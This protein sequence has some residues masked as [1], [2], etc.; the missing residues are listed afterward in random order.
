MKTTQKGFGAN[1]SDKI[2]LEQTTSFLTTERSLVSASSFKRCACISAHK[3]LRG[4]KASMV[5]L[6]R[7][8]LAVVWIA[9]LVFVAWPLALFLFPFYV[10]LQPFAAI[11]GGLGRVVKDIVDFMARYV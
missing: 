9:L 11:P 6:E 10:F 2:V 5:R 3:L 4:I 8:V 1:H 7:L